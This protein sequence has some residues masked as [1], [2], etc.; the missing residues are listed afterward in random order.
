MSKKEKQMKFEAAA[1][2]VTGIILCA[3]TSSRANLTYN[4]I[5]HMLGTKT[6]IETVLDTFANSKASCIVLVANPKDIPDLK[7]I[8]AEYK[9][10]KSIVVIEG[11][12]TRTQSVKNGLNATTS[13]TDIVAIHDGARPFITKELID[14]SI[15]SAVIN[16]SGVLAIPAIDTPVQTNGEKI[17]QTLNRETIFNTQTP[18]TFAFAQIKQAY[19][20]IPDDA[21]Y[22]DDASV[23]ALGGFTPYIVKGCSSN[24]KLTTPYD[25]LSLYNT[26]SKDFRI[27]C[28]FDVH[29]LVKNRP[30]I[31]GGVKVPF[32]LGLLGH[33][34]ADVLTH[35]VM[36]ALLSGSN[37]P[38]IGNQ[39]P[40]FDNKYKNA[41]SINLLKIICQKIK[42][43]GFSVR[44]ISCIIM[45]QQPKLS[46]LVEEMA[47]TLA[48]TISINKKLVTISCTTTEKLGIVGKGRGIAASCSALLSFDDFNK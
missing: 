42:N 36:D 44:N 32:S 9:Q 5:L 41:D 6:V 34:D 10:F 27:G 33:S 39:F 45:A 14:N 22:T 7:N 4:K 15:N 18:Q 21:V 25:F 12:K 30:L 20:K 16:G 40:D 29:K 8:A 38:D 13:A 47:E 35:A 31:L 43:K 3:G 23:F 19:K 28:G 2:Q 17:L 24:K 37:L 46:G 1:P 48:K 11:G 26:Y